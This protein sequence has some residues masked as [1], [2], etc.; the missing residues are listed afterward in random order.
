MIA[1][2]LIPLLTNHKIHIHDKNSLD[3]LRTL[4]ASLAPGS[5]RQVTR[6]YG[7]F[8]QNSW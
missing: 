5:L 8:P 3:L 4:F 1:D 7:S 2:F 6:I